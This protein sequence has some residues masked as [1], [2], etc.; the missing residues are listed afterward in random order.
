MVVFSA[1]ALMAYLGRGDRREE[2]RLIEKH[3]AVVW[4]EATT[5]E[6]L[7]L[8]EEFIGVGVGM[9]EPEIV[10][11]SLHSLSYALLTDR[12]KYPATIKVD[13][14]LVNDQLIYLSEKNTTIT[15]VDEGK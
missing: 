14:D 11:H 4:Q 10:K 9:P 13:G 5:I 15:N 12:V 7:A 2:E 1:I 6:K 8:L 3:C